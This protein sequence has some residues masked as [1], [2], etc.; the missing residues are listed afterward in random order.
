LE[1]GRESGKV[2]RT[3]V[4]LNYKGCATRLEQPTLMRLFAAALK[5]VIVAACVRKNS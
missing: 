2:N 5:A 4:K 1:S 3:L